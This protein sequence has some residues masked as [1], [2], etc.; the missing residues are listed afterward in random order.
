M[1]GR[2]PWPPLEI[3]YAHRTQIDRVIAQDPRGPLFYDD[4]DTN[5]VVLLLFPDAQFEIVVQTVDAAV[6]TGAVVP[7]RV[8]LLYPEGRMLSR[9]EPRTLCS[10][11]PPQERA[12]SGRAGP[13]G[14]RRTSPHPPGSTYAG[15]AGRARVW[16]RVRSRHAG[17]STCP[18]PA[19]ARHAR[20][21]LPVDHRGAPGLFWSVLSGRLAW[22]RSSTCSPPWNPASRSV[23]WTT[24]HVQVG[25]V[26]FRGRIQRGMSVAPV[27]N[28][29]NWM[30]GATSFGSRSIAREFRSLAAARQRLAPPGL[31]CVKDRQPT[32]REAVSRSRLDAGARLGKIF[33]GRRRGRNLGA[34]RCMTARNRISGS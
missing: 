14:P 17:T 27:P 13:R 22:H 16:P 31:T 15:I 7:R 10:F 3:V 25:D 18:R 4:I 28:S 11:G 9:Y 5:H 26:V 32:P 2:S 1:I 12:G 8:E 23:I 24:H 33:R 30:V 19:Q 34:Q 29:A 21:D 20:S 6:E